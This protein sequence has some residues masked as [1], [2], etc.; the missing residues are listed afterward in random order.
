MTSDITVPKQFLHAKL[1]VVAVR[2]QMILELKSL[3]E[4]EKR[5]AIDDMINRQMR[6]I[7]IYGYMD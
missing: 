5:E 7:E 4:R 6:D 3:N 1:T 2:T